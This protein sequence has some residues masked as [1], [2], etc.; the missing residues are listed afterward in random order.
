MYLLKQSMM[1]V[2][3][4]SPTANYIEYN[5]N[6]IRSFLLYCYSICIVH[7]NLSFVTKSGEKKW[8]WAE[9]NYEKIKK[10]IQK[11]N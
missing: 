5:I 11:Q 8:G 7:S 1:Y 10:Q 3:D 6:K 2:V 9:I 4:I